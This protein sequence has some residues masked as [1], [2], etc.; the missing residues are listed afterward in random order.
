MKKIFPSII[1]TLSILIIILAVYL[2]IPN[3]KEHKSGLFSQETEGDRNSRIE[4]ETRML[5]NPSTGKI[6]Q[7]H[8]I[9]ELNSAREILQLQRLKN[10]RDKVVWAE[11]WSFAGPQNVGGR[12][13]AAAYDTRNENT[14]LAAGV[15]SG[16][17]RSEDGGN[18]WK[19]TSSDSPN[20]S[21]SCIIQDPRPGKQD[22]WYYGTGERLGNSASAEGSP[23]RGYGIYKSTDNGI[24]WKLLPATKPTSNNSIVSPYQYVW[25]VLVSPNSTNQ[26]LVF[27][28]TVGG[29]YRSTDGGQTWGACKGEFSNRMSEITDL[30]IVPNGDLYAAFSSISFS[31]TNN[32]PDKG[33]YRSS[34]NGDTWQNI[35]PTDF[36]E[37]IQRT[38]MHYSG[39]E[40][41]EIY[42]LSHT[43]GSGV[44]NHNF[45]TYSIKNNQWKNISTNIPNRTNYELNSQ[46]GY[47]L[48]INILPSDPDYVV[49]GG[50]NL[51]L[52][53]TG[54]KTNDS[55]VI[56]GYDLGSEPFN[57]YPGSWVDYHT[58]FFSKNNPNKLYVGCD[59]GVRYISDIKSDNISWTELN[60]GYVSSQFYGVAMDLST[61]EKNPILVGGLQDRGSY[62]SKLSSQTKNWD[63]IPVAGDG[64]IAAVANGGNILY[65]TTQFGKLYQ[66]KCLNDPKPCTQEIT[67]QEANVTL[68][69]NPFV[70]DPNNSDIAYYPGQNYIYRNKTL[71]NY[72]ETNPGWEKLNN[73]IVDDDITALK[74]SRK[75]ENILYYGT[76][77]GKLYKIEDADEGDKVRTEI[78]GTDFPGNGY[79]SSIAIHPKKASEIIV[80]FSNYGINSIFLSKD[81]GQTWQHIGGNLDKDI[82]FGPSIRSSE[83]ILDI[84]EKPL[85]IVGS[86]IGIF[87]TK[88]PLSSPVEWIMQNPQTVGNAVITGLSGRED[89][90]IVASSH[91]N[92]VFKA[93]ASRLSG[94]EDFHNQNSLNVSIYPN[95]VIG[96][97]V[98]IELNSNKNTSATL[99]LYDLKARSIQFSIQKD[100]VVGLNTINIPTEEIPQG[101]SIVRIKTEANDF[102]QSF[103]LLK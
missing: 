30:I 15:S 36:P 80:T 41:Q 49:I 22:I 47:D 32:S 78:T 67:P 88:E 26:D 91:G 64:G 29:I 13:R 72:K 6:P 59:G 79:I 93:K 40:N 1:L 52:S 43:P 39:N 48:C 87:A 102:W 73:S 84:D 31:G 46:G 10:S 60:T 86:S 103:R 11:D 35:N 55:R 42:F 100:I 14:L 28:A 75:P 68:F 99:E 45:W 51:Y 62:M 65:I 96:S 50:T 63:V 12:T 24:S 21:V 57:I 54:F 71:S 3:Q 5:I 33:F 66:I 69:V 27:A 7:N 20:H 37:R 61:K 83:I 89:G 8:R 44:N 90:I 16:M 70:L 9:R 81:S 25:K 97:S 34:D 4:Y 19:I 94:I 58:L 82:E 98:S 23:Y 95:P 74:V 76:S 18:S 85:Y 77:N 17:Y 92:G 101:I 53:K 38:V 56:G 2:I